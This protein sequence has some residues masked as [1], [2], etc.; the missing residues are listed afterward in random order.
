MADVRSRRLELKRA[1]RAR[2]TANAKIVA[3]FG[4][5][6]ARAKFRGRLVDEKG[7]FV[8]SEPGTP[9]RIRFAAARRSIGAEVVARPNEIVARYGYKRHSEASAYGRRLELGYQ[10]VDASGRHV[11]QAPRPHLRPVLAENREMLRR[12]MLK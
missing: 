1:L 12:M 5:G 10:G 9:P 11:S 7:R 8:P 4:A 6:Q 2:L 3:E